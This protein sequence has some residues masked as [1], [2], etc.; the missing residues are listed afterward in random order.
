MKWQNV[1]IFISSTF[2][3]MHAERDYLIKRVFPE[4]RLWCAEH[5]LKL[6]DI[7]LR[8]GVSEKDATENKRVVDVCL[9]NVDKCRPFLLCLLGQRR[10]WVPGLSDINEETLV[11]FPGLKEYIG[12]R[13]ITELE[14]IHGL[15]HPLNDGKAGMRHAFF[16]HRE[17]D[18]IKNIA[19]E[20]IRQVFELDADDSFME[21]LK[22]TYDVLDYSA[23]WNPNKVSL[24]L[25]NVQGN[26][27]SQGRLENFKVGD[28]P[29]AIVVASQLKEAIADEFPEHF[30]DAEELDD[31]GRELNHQDNFLFSACD[32]YISRLYEETKVLDYLNGDANKPCIFM[33]DAGTGKTSML[34]W[35]I[36]EKQIAENV[37]YRFIGTSSASSDVAHTLQQ[38]TEEL[39][40]KKLITEDDL[41][42]A[43]TNIM[44]KFPTVLK[45]IKGKCNII[46][47]A[48]D[49]WNHLTPSSFRWLPEVLPEN[50]KILLSVKKDGQADII[51]HLTNKDYLVQELS[52][53]SDDHEKTAIIAGYLSSFLKDIDEKQIAHILSLSGSGN[54][55][56]LKI[57]LNELRIHGS[58]DTLMDQLH[59][60]YGTTPKEAFQMVLNRLET[61]EFDAGIPS[62]DLVKYVLGTI[63][64]STEGVLIEEF[65]AICK[66]RIAECKELETDDIMDAVYGLVRH[67]SAY[68]VI[69][70]NR[71]NFLYD[72]F[73]RAVNERYASAYNEFHYL[74]T[75][76]YSRYCYK[77]GGATY[78]VLETTYLTNY[79][80]H[81]SECSKAWAETILT[82]PWFVYRMVSKVSA[83]QTATYFR[84]IAEKYPDSEEYLAI[85]DFMDR[86][87]MRL[88]IGP[89]TLFDS[90]KRYVGLDNSLVYQLCDKASKVMELEYYY[91]AKEEI[92]AGLTAD[93]ELDLYTG[94]GEEL[95]KPEP[96]VWKDYII[97]IEGSTILFQ[98]MYTE[99]IERQVTLARKPFRFYVGGD[100]LYVHYAQ[101]GDI[102]NGDIETFRLPT[103]E[104]VFSQDVRPE[105]P[106]KFN[107]YMIAFGIDGVQYQYSMDYDE[108]FPEMYAYNMNTC[109][110]QIHSTF[111]TDLEKKREYSGH[112]VK[113]CG[114]YL[115]EES[116]MLEKC[117]IWHVPTGR[118][119]IETDCDWYHFIACE[120]QDMW[121]VAMTR[122]G[123]M[124]AYH[125]RKESED[126]ITLIDQFE[127]THKP[128]VRVEQIGVLD[129]NLYL[130]FNSGDFWIFNEKFE[131]IGRQKLP[132][133]I[134]TYSARNYSGNQFLYANGDYIFFLIDSQVLFFEKKKYMSLLLKDMEISQN[135]DAYTSLQF[136]NTLTL[137]G[138]HACH[139][140]N[141][142][143]LRY[144]YSEK[145]PGFTFYDP[146]IIE[147]GSNRYI[148]DVREDEEKFAVTMINAY[149]L[150]VGL[151]FFA[152]KPEGVK[153]T[154]FAF[155]HDGL[156][157]VVF[158]NKEVIDCEVRERAV[159]PELID[160]N[161]PPVQKVETKDYH[162]LTVA[163]YDTRD[164]FKCVDVWRLDGEVPLPQCI[165][166]MT[167]KGTPY[168]VF[169]QIYVDVDHSETRVYH[170][171]TKELVY[172]Y[173]Y[174]HTV[175][176][177][178]A[179]N[180]M[181]ILN[182]KIFVRNYNYLTSSQHFMEIDIF[183][184]TTD[185]HILSARNVRGI[186]DRDL[187]L[188]SAPE[189]H[190]VI[191]DM[192]K[193]EIKREFKTRL[194]RFCYNVIPKGNRLVVCLSGGVCEVYD[195]ETLQ[196][197][198]SQMLLPNY[199]RVKDLKGTDLIFTTKDS[200]D[201][202]I[203]KAGNTRD[204]MKGLKVNCTTT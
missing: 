161:N 98:N 204:L 56:Y 57:V 128:L 105:K 174:D 138:K 163:Y 154:E 48:V 190:I 116:H 24:E 27:L 178:G 131:F 114:E 52:A 72:S 65:G 40:R 158:W 5:K 58:F 1:Y 90:L 10:G 189:N 70:G 33:A 17:P 151:R 182:D 167:I 71:V 78:D 31:I 130:F 139:A 83:G 69:D 37:I 49:Q 104:S 129:G 127:M 63:G 89:N 115:K 148:S 171:I 26:D 187:Y 2:N 200:S 157:G 198:Y 35:L 60:N 47:D 133:K 32:S 13:S 112:E 92:A 86:Y 85:A 172:R 137:L 11:K 28:V 196:Y 46:L 55:L 103:L 94:T 107:W 125:Y 45:K 168:I 54:P 153:R 41:E 194:G 101:I 140:L 120:N 67:L 164:N 79:I 87:S 118:M 39:T 42:D 34:A 143:N 64:C 147:I 202:T 117:R 134:D 169:S 15:L 152:K 80:H 165:D 155:Y 3:D 77:K 201:Y 21:S 30:A 20:D 181:D 25:K 59:K 150:S 88:N 175:Y 74:L 123:H 84:K 97:Y 75:M 50:V 180:E 146:R 119:L 176:S 36:G 91:P 108:T 136:G 29:L 76:L 184:Q 156:V 132:F 191:Y 62:A 53:I 38:L 122:E 186:Y 179:C 173:H 149:N 195:K 203:F 113:W 18:Y 61:E 102:E 160:P 185:E 199:N 106:E 66:N 22:E 109:E 177:F 170:A 95:H 12:K 7:D 141:L 193:K 135:T 14:I 197:L 142:H 4:L 99:E 111:S 82:E 183:E 68:L 6:I 81:A 96:F 8:W 44:L 192:D 43:K 16:Y 73:R 23:E 162:K 93:R 110:V 9:N 144:A 51:E 159:N 145:H 121:Y 100:Y 126:V 124:T 188:F 166:V 19:R